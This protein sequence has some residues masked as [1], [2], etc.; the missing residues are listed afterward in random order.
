MKANC[1]FDKVYNRFVNLSTI[2]I[3]IEWQYTYN[4]LHFYYSK[5]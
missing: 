4:V 2:D 5:L 3:W 1:V